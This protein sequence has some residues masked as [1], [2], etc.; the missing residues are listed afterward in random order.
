MKAHRF[1]SMIRFVCPLVLFCIL[2]ASLWVTNFPAQAISTASA[3]KPPSF[4][5]RLRP[6]LLANM[7]QLR[8]PG[9]VIYVDD[10]NQGS[11]TTGLGIGNLATREPMQVDNSMRIASI[12][13]TLT[14]TVILQLVDRHKLGL[15]DPV[16]TYLPEVPNGKN[17]TI[18][19]LLN[20]SSGLFS[21]TEDQG[22]Q[23][24][25]LMGFDP[26]K[27]WQPEELLTIAFKHPPYFAPGK[28]FH[29]SNFGPLGMHQT[30]L[31]PLSSSAIPDPHAQGYIYG[32]DNTGTGPTLNVTDWNPSSGW[33]AG[34]T[35]LGDVLP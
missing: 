11:W 28:G 13:K 12:T 34:A 1:H 3:S 22:F 33:T 7:Q 24:Q 2:A 4:V 32:T 8:I 29:Y 18:R 26:Y 25:A 19:Q 15:D 5:A 17:I 27:V 14:G 16:S 31:P 30:S 9:G 10:P 23:K 6:L 35:E 21:Y 20:M